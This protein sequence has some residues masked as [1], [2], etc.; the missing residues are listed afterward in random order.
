MLEVAAQAPAPDDEHDPSELIGR[1]LG[2]EYKVTGLVGV[3]GIGRVYRAEHLVLKRPVALKVLLE[4]YQ[5]VPAL[6]R[7]FEREAMA[8]AA[9]S[10]PNIVTI[11]DYVSTKDATFLVMELVEGKELV[12]LLNVP[13]F[14][15]ADAFAV[16]EQILSSLAYA[17]A[18]E[19]IH[20]DLKPQNVLVRLLPG[21]RYHAEIL[22]FGLAKFMDGS[23]PGQNLTKTGLIVGTP[24]Y[25]APEQATGASSDQRADVYAAGI[26]FFE[27]LAG[28]HPWKGSE[29]ADLLRQ[30]LLA[31][32]P[33]LAERCP[34]ARVAPELE[35]FIARALAKDGADRFADG[36]AMLDAFLA[37]PRDAFV[38]GADKARTA[39]AERPTGYAHTK[40]AVPAAISQP[41]RAVS[42]ATST[43][44]I[45]RIAGIATISALV[46]AAIVFVAVDWATNSS[47]P[48]PPAVSAAPE[49][50]RVPD[51]PR[52]DEVT[53][54]PEAPIAAGD[55]VSEEE[56]ALEQDPDPT[57][58]E[59][60]DAP[61]EETEDVA[62][63]PAPP[64]PAARP[65]AANPWAGSEP[66][67]LS[68]VH[69]RVARGSAITKRHM[70]QVA[71][72]RR[73]HPNDVRA[74]LLLAQA[75][76][77]RSW[78]SAGLDQYRRAYRRQPS[79][80]GDPRMQ[81]DLVRMAGTESLHT[82]ATAA[83]VEIY[84]REATAAV[85][86]AIERERDAASR[87]RL[88]QA[89]AAVRA[90]P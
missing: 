55:E 90:A 56:A 44:S 20:R 2:D 64:P 43:R 60:A 62:D 15:S 67:T 61:L 58:D 40:P 59:I 38:P 16:M 29:G 24:A 23:G 57:L 76:T 72:Y 82:E 11:T 22:D 31:P 73:R 42:A 26:M 47:S 84:G 34:G 41:Q 77:A 51:A 27:M 4:Q 74:T 36:G 66:P 37:L 78:L 8:L 79:S 3:G 9:L 13:S 7:R 70:R 50:P 88:T 54:E 6:Q 19:V 68:R 86:R 1:T 12:D 89:L 87:A 30:H 48:P 14:T 45:A 10:H 81:R 49:E 63:V 17:H 35:T 33:K 71:A 25:M 52:E 53:D 32:V 18:R 85:E 80:R 83:L 5:C 28:E 46:L 75:Y 69:R 65:P 39:R 21:G